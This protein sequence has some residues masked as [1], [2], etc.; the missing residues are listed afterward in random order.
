MRKSIR[1]AVIKRD[2]FCV[3]CGSAVDK[4]CAVHHR[5][6]RS[7]AGKDVLS[8]LI[9]LCHACHNLGSDSVHL[10]PRTAAEN[11]WIVKSFE[12]PALVPVR[13]QQDRWVYLDDEGTVR[14]VE[15]GM[16]EVKW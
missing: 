15:D 1:A 4:D 2:R 14:D 16:V 10:N 7:Q 9:A 6:L 13:Y 3:K 12:D 5:K 11:G 8:N